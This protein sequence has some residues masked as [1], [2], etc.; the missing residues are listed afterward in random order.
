MK[1][2]ALTNHGVIVLI[3]LL[4]PILLSAG[5][6]NCSVNA[7][8]YVALDARATRYDTISQNWTSEEWLFLTI[9]KALGRLALKQKS[10]H[11]DSITN[12]LESENGTNGL[13]ERSRK[14]VGRVFFGPV[15]VGV[16]Y[17]KYLQK[18]PSKVLLL[19]EYLFVELVLPNRPP[20][21]Y[22][23]DSCGVIFTDTLGHAEAII[24]STPLGKLPLLY[25]LTTLN[26]AGI[27]V[28]E[29]EVK[30]DK[31]L[32]TIWDEKSRTQASA[33]LNIRSQ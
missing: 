20:L 21:F 1:L 12:V 29:L 33:A 24:S 8:E 15:R 30:K 4:T 10:S 14:D 9:V 16:F 5:D 25:F 22:F 31:V 3:L 19:W 11:R 18:S 6:L 27:Y 2:C 32:V 23:P 7:E 17:K 26:D 13:W 28:D